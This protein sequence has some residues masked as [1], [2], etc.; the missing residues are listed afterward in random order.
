[1]RQI[2]QMS[3]Q[4]IETLHLKGMLKH[5]SRKEVDRARIQIQQNRID[6]CDTL[7]DYI[8]DDVPHAQQQPLKGQLET[9]KRDL[10]SEMEDARNESLP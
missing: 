4:Q 3:E 5:P 7:L 2:D 8:H 10:E 6:A 1:M 9:L